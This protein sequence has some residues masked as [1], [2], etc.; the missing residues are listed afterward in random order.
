M[1][2]TMTPV[3]AHLTFQDVL[4]SIPVYANAIGALTFNAIIYAMFI[5]YISD[6]ANNI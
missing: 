4:H 3:V 6:S 5:K 1:E 2:T